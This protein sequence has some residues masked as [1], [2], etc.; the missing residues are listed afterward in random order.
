MLKENRKK[1]LI[2]TYYTYLL[3]KLAKLLLV[4]K[5]IS[6]HLNT[7]LGNPV[8]IVRSIVSYKL[9]THIYIHTYVYKHNKVNAMKTAWYTL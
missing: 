5:D 2:G 4:L 7:T 1:D 3:L 8:C 6:F 9:Y